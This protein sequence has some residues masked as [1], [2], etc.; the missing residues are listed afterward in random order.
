LDNAEFLYTSNP[1]KIFLVQFALVF[2][3]AA[4]CY[5]FMHS[6]IY[7][8]A[9]VVG[10]ISMLPFYWFKQSAFQ[11]QHSFYCDTGFQQTST[12]RDAYIVLLAWPLFA[13][14]S[15]GIAAPYAAFKIQQYRTQTTSIG[16]YT[17]SFSAN[18]KNYLQLLPPLLIAE[19]VTFACIYYREYLPL[20]F[21]L[22]LIAGLWLLVFVRWWVVLVNLQW[23]ATS[24]RLGY[25]VATWDLP[26]YNKL[27]A[28][29][30]LFCLI[31]LGFYWPWAKIHIAEYKATH[32]AF[33]ANQRFKKWKNN[34]LE[35]GQIVVANNSVC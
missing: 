1:Q 25:F 9:G 4:L 15:V 24:T 34:L 28:N 27:I 12:L 32:L 20:G 31:T 23:N 2:Y 8:T 22:L 29:K 26:S 13:V 5:A 19:I 16:G 14:L 6:P 35:T 17:F 3:V 21:L 11:Q 10:L 30:L 18:I 33:F 7:F